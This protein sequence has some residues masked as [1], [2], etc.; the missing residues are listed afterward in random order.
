MQGLHSPSNIAFSWLL[1]LRWGAVA[2]QALLILA[3]YLIFDIKVPVFIVAFVLLFQIVSNLYFFYLKRRKAVHDWL[4][5]TVMFVDVS[6]LTVLLYFAGGPMNPFTFLFL[7]HTVLGAI[8][9]RPRWAWG[10]AAFTVLCYACLFFPG[11]GY[12]AE[13]AEGSAF[14]A[15]PLCH[16]PATSG[17]GGANYM[18]IHLQGMWFAFSITA[19]FIV[20]FVGRIQRALEGHQRIIARLQEEKVRNEKLASLATLAA[21][22]A[23][24][25]STPL[26]TIAV[27]AGEMF[28]FLKDGKGEPQLLEDVTLIRQQVEKC[29]E[30]IFQMAADAGEHMG[31][32][33]EEFSL[34]QLVGEVLDTFADE[35]PEV[36]VTV[37]NQADDRQLR[38]PYRTFVRTLKG[39]LKNASDASTSAAPIT[40]TCLDDVDFLYFEVEDKGE[41]MDSE[42]LAKACE[43]FFTRKEAGQ[44]LGL[45]L[46]LARSFAERFGGNLNIFSEPGRGT[47]VVFSLSSKHIAAAK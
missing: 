15:V 25:F 34:R 31:E 10:L 3:V 45:G 38:V 7:I 24:E 20:F 30:I 41:G 5:N 18:N 2:C 29:K 47:R 27:A 11:M 43:P 13:T 44:G 36:E 39:L 23:H 26:S 28:H 33:V 21:G 9:M 4:F 6:L 1:L 19:F 37:N 17:L 22:A 35:E 32:A 14:Q 46:Y 12:S 40:L 16:D 8:L 42:T